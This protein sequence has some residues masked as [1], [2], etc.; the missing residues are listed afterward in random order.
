MFMGL[1]DQARLPI[2]SLSEPLD[3]DSDRAA[4]DWPRTGT[5]CMAGSDGNNVTP[6]PPTI[7]TAQD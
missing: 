4:V 6:R 1:A 5:E 2:P 3:L 7:A